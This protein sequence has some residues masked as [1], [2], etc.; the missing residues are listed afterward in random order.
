[1]IAG[2][3][4]NIVVNYLLMFQLEMGIRGAAIGTVMAQILVLVSSLLILRKTVQ[5]HAYLNKR[6]VFETVRTGITAFGISLAPTIT[7]IFTNF[8]CLRY[9]GDAAVACY[10]VISYIVFPVQYL[11]TGIGDGVQPLLSYYNG[12]GRK[13]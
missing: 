8:Q 11:L 3:I 9:G 2:F 12:A 1:M 5:I 6:I 13:K 7:L 10:A 4:T